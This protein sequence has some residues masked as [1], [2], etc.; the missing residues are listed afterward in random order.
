MALLYNSSL[1]SRPGMAMSTQP[2]P[3]PAQYTDIEPLVKD[4]T[5]FN[6]AYR[7]GA[8]LIGDMEYDALV[9]RAVGRAGAIRAA[10]GLA[11]QKM[12][13]LLFLCQVN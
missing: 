13:F 8:S 10:T 5:R 6:K 7:D 11:L 4:L 12:H 9:E 3:T 2:A 1:P